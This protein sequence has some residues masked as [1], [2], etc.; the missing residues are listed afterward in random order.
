LGFVWCRLVQDVASKT[1]E[2][3][4]DGTTTAT[5][6]A[7]AIY[8]EGV[9]TVAAGAC[10]PLSLAVVYAVSRLALPCALSDARVRGCR[11][12]L[13]EQVATPWTSDEDPSELL[14]RSSRFSRLTSGSSPPALRSLRYAYLL[15]SLPVASSSALCETQRLIET[16]RDGW[17]GRYHLGQRRRA[18]WSP[19]RQRYGEG[20]TRGCHHRQGGQDHRGHCACSP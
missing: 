2:A 17:A 7:R 1:N 14:R 11:W 6:L 19:D 9:K 3:A 16:T 5:V 12:F 4:G 18:H 10:F 20:W 8:A 13:V 15:S